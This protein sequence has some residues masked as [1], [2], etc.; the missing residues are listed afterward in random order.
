[1]RMPDELKHPSGG[2]TIDR[3]VRETVRLA[4]R[5]LE[6]FPDLMRKHKFIAGGAAV[7]STLVVLAG[8]AIAHRMGSGATA[9]EAVESVTAEELQGLRVF[10]PPPARNGD[11][12]S[13]RDKRPRAGVTHST[14]GEAAGKVAREAADQPHATE[15]PPPG[16]G[17][18]PATRP[19]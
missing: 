10:R 13:S 19:V 15:P 5:A 2:E 7:S 9:E 4:H 16:N 1:M 11:G 14:N 8:V 18:R 17:P 3:T 6:R 12:A